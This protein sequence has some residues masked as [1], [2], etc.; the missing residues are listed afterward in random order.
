MRNVLDGID[1]IEHFVL[2]GTRQLDLDIG[3]EMIRH[4]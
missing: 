3:L 4:L 1:V 2:H